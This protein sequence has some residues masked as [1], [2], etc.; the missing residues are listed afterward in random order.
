ML[1]KCFPKIVPLQDIVEKNGIRCM[2]F[3][4]WVTNTT[5]TTTTTTTH[6]H[7]LAHTHTRTR[8]YIHTYIRVI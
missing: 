4:Y 3:A 6:T 2:H 7:A 8:T 5:P 1:N